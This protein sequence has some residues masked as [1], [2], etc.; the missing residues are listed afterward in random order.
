MGLEETVIA[1]RSREAVEKVRRETWEAAQKEVDQVKREADQAKKEV[2]FTDLTNLIKSFVKFPNWTIQEVADFF[3]IK[4]VKIKKLKAILAYPSEE[5]I[6]EGTQ[7]LF[8]RN[9]ALDEK[10]QKRLEDLVKLYKKNIAKN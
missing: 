5:K 2:A 4:E 9:L 1:Y 7:K 6:Q 10:E 8:F 3:E